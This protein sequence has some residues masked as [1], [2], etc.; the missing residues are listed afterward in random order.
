MVL[1][2]VKLLDPNEIAEV[3]KVAM[4]MHPEMT[5]R[6]LRDKLFKILKKAFDISDVSQLRLWKPNSN[7]SK[8]KA[9]ADFLRQ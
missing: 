6:Q 9:I 2:P 8:P 5:F 3:Q 1:P 7:H 4:F